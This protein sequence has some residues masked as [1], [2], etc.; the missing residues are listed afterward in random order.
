MHTD[1]DT[2]PEIVP[3]MR[4]LFGRTDLR[5]SV[6]WAD[7][8]HA[9]DRVAP[10]FFDRYTMRAFSSR[11][12]GEP[13]WVALPDLNADGGYSQPGSPVVAF[14]TSERDARTYTGARAW[15]GK[16]RYTVRLFNGRRITC[17]VG[18][19]YGQFATRAEALRAL[20]ALPRL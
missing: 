12:V 11:K 9:V 7:L 2:I 18:M 17:P 8:I 5:G 3:A 10:H 16:R 15:G 19:T 14:V 6:G 20:A 4:H 1:T 13:R